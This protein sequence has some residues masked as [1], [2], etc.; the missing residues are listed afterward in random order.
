[1]S[2]IEMIARYLAGPMTG[3]LTQ[4]GYSTA[5]CTGD[6]AFALLSVDKRF[7]NAYTLEKVLEK[8]TRFSI[9]SYEAC[10]QRFKEALA[11]APKIAFSNIN[12]LLIYFTQARQMGYSLEAIISPRELT[13]FEENI[14]ASYQFFYFVSLLGKHIHP[15]FKVISGIEGKAFDSA[16]T[17]LNYEY[18]IQNIKE[19]KINMEEIAAN[20]SDENLEKALLV[21][22][23]P[24][25]CNLSVKQFFCLKADYSESRQNPRAYDP[26]EDIEPSDYAV[27][28][29]SINHSS[30]KIEDLL[31]D[32]LLRRRKQPFFQMLGDKVIE[33]IAVLKEKVKLFNQLLKADDDRF[34]FTEEQKAFL[35][36]QFP[37]VL[38]CESSKKIYLKDKTMQE[39][40]SSQPLQ[41]GKDIKIVATDN[42]D[43][44][45]TILDYLSVNNIDNVQVILFED[46]KKCKETGQSPLALLAANE[47]ILPKENN[48]FEEKEPLQHPAVIEQS[49][50]K[51]SS[52]DSDNSQY[53]HSKRSIKPAPGVN[54]FNA[55]LSKENPI[56]SRTEFLNKDY[57]QL[58]KDVLQLVDIKFST[59]STNSLNFDEEV[60]QNSVIKNAI[61]SSI[62][63]IIKR[64]VDEMAKTSGDAQ[65]HIKSLIVLK[66]VL[67][68]PCI[69]TIDD[70]IVRSNQLSGA[71]VT[72]KIFGG[73][74]LCLAGALTMAFAVLLTSVTT[75]VSLGL[76]APLSLPVG[77]TLAAVGVGILDTGAFL[78]WSGCHDYQKR[79]DPISVEFRNL[80]QALKG[81][82]EETSIHNTM[83]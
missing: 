2:P 4:G 27:F 8:Y 13:L 14:E 72:K 16:K 7:N 15:D 57:E 19:N 43:H 37:V 63:C 74:L 68:K 62:P 28:C 21:L 6:T 67:E 32:F 10:L 17:Y 53:D 82:P 50:A 56:P 70:C 71:Q 33:P 77:I 55:A 20:P 3:E 34:L 81:N 69:K 25:A 76:S 47:S 54:F 26:E 75:A 80:F 35:T 79:Q 51:N 23:L 36:K 46:L 38:I 52:K 31:G 30:S 11:I 44:R 22:K 66:A 41:L 60:L 83:I 58:K 5:D 1:M 59:P 9:T 24:E 64:L 18:I 39:Y 65:E 40:R 78:I 45:A 29:L 48:N 12:L 42:N 49:F 61:L 73:L